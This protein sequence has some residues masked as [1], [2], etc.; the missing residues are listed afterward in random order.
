[1]KVVLAKKAGFCMGVRKAMD[2]VLAALKTK[3]KPVSTFGPLIHN[4]Q[5]LDLLASK[6]VSV[7]RSVSEITGGTVVIRAHGIPPQQRDEILR[8]GAQVVDGTC[9]RVV[10]V[11]TIIQRFSRRGYHVVIVGDEGH[12]EVLGLLGFAQGRGILV[13]TAADVA[14]LP[15]LDKYIVV[16]QTTQ[17]EALFHD[18]ASE[19]TAKYSGGEIFNTICHSTHERQAEILELCKNVDAV[20]VVGGV[21]SANTKRLA[22]IARE[23]GIKAYHVETE[24]DL[25]LKEMSHFSLVA[26]TAGASTP[27]WI[28]NRVVSKLE[29]IKGERESAFK[30]GVYS[31]SRFLLQS[32]IYASLGAGFLTY[33]SLKLQDIGGAL[34]YFLIAGTYTYTAHNLNHLTD[35]EA[36]AFSDPG[37]AMFFSAH[38]KS[39]LVMS[40]L[41]IAS[42]LFLAYLSGWLPFLFL[43]VISISGT[44]YGVRIIPDSLLPS[45]PFR[46]LKD[47]PGSKTLFI[48]L[49]WGAVAALL[50]A[51]G[52]GRGF[53]PSLAVAFLFVFAFVYVRSALTEIFDVQ[54][55]RL[56][57]RETLPIL[58][59]EKSTVGLLKG[60]TVFLVLLLVA[61][62]ALGYVTSASYWLVLPVLLMGACILLFEKKYLRR[63]VKSE[64]LIESTFILAGLLSYIWTRI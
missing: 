64:I 39:I 28:I 36:D 32:N 42:S 18:I 19:I 54:A 43:L 15:E 8:T 52:S 46:R 33:A 63:S 59:G 35:K 40:L 47:I 49:A 45:V 20:V 4:Q 5:V 29:G 11:Q 14:K 9:R 41:A 23:A 7:V 60:I 13:S 1:M 12:P 34:Q 27:N 62:G 38:E 30:A 3:Q 44:L 21:E 6:G 16:A 56:V 53:A 22:Q 58:I 26:V 17:D 37:R 10:K 48:A 50:P 57:G 31:L 25:D 24:K 55:D 51:W 61:S 2:T